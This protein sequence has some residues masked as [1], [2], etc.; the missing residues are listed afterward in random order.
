MTARLTGFRPLLGKEL[1][2]QWRTLRLPILVV[3]FLVIGFGS[4]VLARFTPELVR[5]VAGDQ[6]S[7]QLPPPT[8]ADA[9]DQLLKNVTQ[10]GTL[11]AILLAMGSIATEK[12]A[13]TAALLLTG[14]VARPAFLAAKAVALGATMALAVAAATATAWLYTAILFAPLPAAQ[15]ALA[16][17]LLWLDLAVFLA[18]TFL[19]SALTRSA[20]AAAGLGFALLLV[21]G[22]LGALPT[23]GSALSTGLA[24]DARSVAL[25][26]AGLDLRPIVSAIAVIVVALGLALAVFEREEL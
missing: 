2:E 13:G 23:I 24:P 10:F 16:G 15:F 19:G 18:L 12:E 4:P 21:L 7:L 17:V 6:F 20:M 22:I 8:A 14:P 25:G 3:V 26:A 11:I 9:V 1:L 5:A